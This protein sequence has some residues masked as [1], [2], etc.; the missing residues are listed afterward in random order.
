MSHKLVPPG[1]W[2][3]L[4][5]PSPVQACVWA[6]LVV[7]LVAAGLV[8]WQQLDTASG[9]PETAPGVA[10]KPD[11]PAPPPAPDET[12][13][14]PAP[15]PAHR[16]PPQPE[17]DPAREPEPAPK[18][19]PHP[20][21]VMLDAANRFALRNPQQFDAAIERF[22]VV[23]QETQ[24][25][26]YSQMARERIDQIRKRR[27]QG[28]ARVMGTLAAKAEKAVAE[29]RFD[30]AIAVFADYQ[31]PLADK[32][33]DRREARVQQLQARKAKWESRRDRRDAEVQRGF[34][35]LV[36]ESARLATEKRFDAAE[37]AVARFRAK[38]AGTEVAEAAAP[39]SAALREMS[40]A[41]EL[42]M[43]TFGQD[44]GNE[45]T[46]RLNDGPVRFKPLKVIGETVAG[47]RLLQSG[48]L[49]ANYTFDQ[50]A[51][52]EVLARLPAIES[53]YAD[54]VRGAL[55]RDFGDPARAKTLFTRS[56]TPF[57]EALAQAVA[58]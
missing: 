7:V 32:T 47:Q 16:P 11:T 38:Y 23:A 10:T 24:G 1:V 50:L 29:H 18:P 55:A 49:E 36:A 28:I 46:V 43:G 21:E 19:E 6:G 31:G 37:K 40:R 2:R 54:C 15:E 53:P 25:T 13:P 5:A 34:Q 56:P 35:A 27:D 42:L 41:G 39:L 33:V 9:D 30:A 48:A 3:N 22:T 45:I 57:K 12:R 8:L 26:K 52:T 14:V 20:G 44:L 58:R 4:K 51:K 17:P